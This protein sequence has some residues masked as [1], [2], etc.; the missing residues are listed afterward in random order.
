MPLLSYPN[1]SDPVK[2]CRITS[3]PTKVV[4]NK[5]NR[6]SFFIFN[7]LFKKS[8][9]IIKIKIINLINIKDLKIGWL[10]NGQSCTFSYS[11]PGLINCIVVERKKYKKY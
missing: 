10:S 9:S 11:N 3:S 6:N 4:Q 8:V 1:I 2:Y 7:I 5:E